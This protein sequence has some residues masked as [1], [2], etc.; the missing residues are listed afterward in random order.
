M[1][2]DGSIIRAYEKG[3]NDGIDIAAAAGDAGQGRRGWHGGGGDARHRKA[4]R[5]W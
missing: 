2:A 1:P 4:R 5:S 3:K